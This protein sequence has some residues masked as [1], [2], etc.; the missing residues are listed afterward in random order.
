MHTAIIPTSPSTLLQGLVVLSLTNCKLDSEQATPMEMGHVSFTEQLCSSLE[1][2]LSRVRF[3]FLGGATIAPGNAPNDE[4]AA[5]LATDH[6]AMLNHSDQKAPYDDQERHDGSLAVLEVT[7]LEEG[8]RRRIEHLLSKRITPRTHIVDLTST[9]VEVLQSLSFQKPTPS[10]FAETEASDHDQ[11]LAM[12]LA[13]EPQEPQELQGSEGATEAG[14]EDWKPLPRRQRRPRS[15]QQPQQEPQP[16]ATVANEAPLAE[17]APHMPNLRLET[18]PEPTMEPSRP[19]MPTEGRE[20]DG[21]GSRPGEMSGAQANEQPACSRCGCSSEFDQYNERRCFCATCHGLG[22]S[23]IFNP[24]DLQDPWSPASTGL[25]ASTEG[26]PNGHRMHQNSFRL[27]QEINASEGR[28]P[29]GAGVGEE[30]GTQTM[31]EVAPMFEDLPADVARCVV[32]GF[33]A[34]TECRNKFGFTPLHSACV[35][36]DVE[37]TRWLIASGARTHVKDIR[38]STPLFRVSP[39]P[40]L[41]ATG[42]AV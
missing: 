17:A 7:F 16:A 22:L 32:A 18:P 6:G 10:S 31:P 14:A 8:A 41:V 5:N 4:N 15:Q 2:T 25:S 21:A 3:L 12:P 20:K 36:G 35:A 13:P 39:N 28:E 27:L 24:V 23:C 1:T 19:P 9:P 40:R 38:G 30:A 29:A 37:R 42:R 34:A 33:T 11:P 26:T